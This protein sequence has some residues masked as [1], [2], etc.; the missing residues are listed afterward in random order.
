MD[1]VARSLISALYDIGRP[2][3]DTL[4]IAVLHGPPK[5][6]L[7]VYLKPWGQLGRKPS[8]KE[9]GAQLLQVLKGAQA[10]LHEV[11]QERTVEVVRSLK[12]QGYRVL[13]LLEEGKDIENVHLGE[14][15]AFVLGDHIGFPVE[16]QRDL[17]AECDEVVSLGKTSYLASHCI[18]YIHEF[19]D[20]RGRS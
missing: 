13:L 11:K 5:P 10:G 8:E 20:R 15:A 1:V 9:A 18:L 14:R 6:P 7:A 19:L 4:F 16:V 3:G 17:E 12:K 2:R